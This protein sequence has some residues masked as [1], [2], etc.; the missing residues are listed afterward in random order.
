MVRLYGRSV[1]VDE[2]KDLK[3]VEDILNKK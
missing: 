2:I 1:A 3:K